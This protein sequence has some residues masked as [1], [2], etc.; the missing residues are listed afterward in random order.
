MRTIKSFVIVVLTAMVMVGCKEYVPVETFV[1]AEDPVSLTPEQKAAREKTEE[2]QAHVKSV[3]DRVAEK[4]GVAA[5]ELNLER[6]I[7][8]SDEEWEDDKKKLADRLNKVKI[9][10]LHNA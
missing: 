9:K 3:L 6:Y 4:M 5:K 1:E 2:Y 7:A 8:S 10:K